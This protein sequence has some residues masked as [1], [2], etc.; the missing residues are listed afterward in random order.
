MAALSV[1][2][3]ARLA[4]IWVGADC[5][6][7]SNDAADFAES[8]FDLNRPAVGELLSE[9]RT[10]I[11][12]T[13][14]LY[15]TDLVGGGHAEGI[16]DNAREVLMVRNLQVLHEVSTLRETAQTLESR[17][18]ELEEQTRRDKLTGIF[19]RAHLDERPFRM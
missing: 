10:Q 17:T 14:A 11:P 19:N 5:A 8:L 4:D 15:Q 7:L 18:H 2:S 9:V 6:S 12:E 16:L 1:F 3:L 13:E